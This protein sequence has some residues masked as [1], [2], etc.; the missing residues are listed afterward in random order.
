M[1][2]LSPID[3]EQIFLKIAFVA[4]HPVIFVSENIFGKSYATLNMNK[5]RF[6][7]CFHQE[8]GLQ[9]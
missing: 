2:L 8:L 3:E 5:L 9:Q 7:F 4:L 6:P 1:F